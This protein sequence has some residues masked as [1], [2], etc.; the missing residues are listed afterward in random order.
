MS[1]AVRYL[2][3]CILAVFSR[4]YGNQSIKDCLVVKT[5]KILLLRKYYDGHNG[6]GTI[7]EQRALE[8]TMRVGVWCTNVRVLYSIL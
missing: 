5:S 3:C 8:A 7:A 6:H 2:V 1:V 4:S